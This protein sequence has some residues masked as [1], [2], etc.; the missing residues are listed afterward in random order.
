[1]SEPEGTARAQPFYCPFCGEEDFVPYDDAGQ[2]HCQ[3]CDRRFLVKML[4]LG[5]EPD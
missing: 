4:G 3:S 5:P 1:V 2:Y